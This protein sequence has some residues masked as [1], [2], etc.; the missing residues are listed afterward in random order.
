MYEALYK[1]YGSR[2]R[3]IAYRMLG[4]VSD[5]EDAVQDVFERLAAAEPVEMQHPKA[6]LAKLTTNRCLNILKS[7]RRRR[8]KY[9]GPWLP[10]PIVEAAVPGPEDQVASRDDV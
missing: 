2:M 5:A 6:Y 3:G 1:E 9:V 8:E 4:S 10:E 7:A